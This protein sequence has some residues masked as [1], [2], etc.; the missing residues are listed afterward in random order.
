M[1]GR[2]PTLAPGRSRVIHGPFGKTKI[3]IPNGP[4]L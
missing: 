1:A 4:W 3:F 2:E